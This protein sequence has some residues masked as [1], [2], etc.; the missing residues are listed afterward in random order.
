MAWSRSKPRTDGQFELLGLAKGNQYLI[1]AV[2]D[3]VPYFRAI[4]EARQRAGYRAAH[5]RF[6]PSAQYSGEGMR[7]CAAFRRAHSSTSIII[8]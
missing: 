7:H 3:G 5:G 1:D 6:R 2:P 8:L 4:A